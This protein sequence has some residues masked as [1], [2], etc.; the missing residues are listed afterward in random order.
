MNAVLEHDVISLVSKCAEEDRSPVFRIG[1]ALGVSL[2]DGCE[3]D[4]Q[5]QIS[6]LLS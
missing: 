5:E 2:V 1:L 3:G 4:G 6:L